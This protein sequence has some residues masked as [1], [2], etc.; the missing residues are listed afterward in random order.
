MDKKDT[1]YLE[2]TLSDT[3]LF[4]PSFVQKDLQNGVFEDV[5]PI[6]K[7]NDNGPIEF[8][9]DNATEKFLD[10]ANSYIK[11]KVKIVKND[12]S[13]LDDENVVVPINYLIGTMFNQVDLVLGGTTVSSSNNLYSYRA[14]LEALLNHGRDSKK[15]QLQMGLYFKDPAGKLEDVTIDGNN[16]VKQKFDIFKGSKIVELSGQLHC[17]L[18]NQ[19]RLMLNGVSLR[20]ILHRNRSPF[21][22]MCAENNPNYKLNI[23]EAVCC[24]R[25]VTLTSH[26]FLELQKQLESTPACSPIDRIDVRTHS[27]AAG[28]NHFIWDN[29]YQGQLPTRIFV[30]LVDNDSASGVFEKNPLNFKNYNIRKVSTLLNGE[31]LPGHPMKLDFTNDQYIDGYRS[32]FSTTSKLN[33]DAGLDISRTDYKNG[34]TLFGFNLTLTLCSNGHS[35]MIKQGTLKVELEFQQALQSTIS[36]IIYAEF[37]NIISIDKY[38]NGIKNF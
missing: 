37:E 19:G 25:K 8:V 17:D 33:S 38:R 2:C 29:C 22:L 4:S 13:N 21:S 7:L 12:G 20:I 10:L 27:V 15:S 28:L 34:Y 32:L 14:Y 1:E 18:F 9:I 26:K 11:F 3:D 6:S 36:V 35:E 24:L 16:A 30:G 5:F 23:V 31:S